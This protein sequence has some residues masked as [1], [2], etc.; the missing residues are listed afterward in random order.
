MN[1]CV[2]FFSFERNASL[3]SCLQKS[4]VIRFRDNG[5]SAGFVMWTLLCI[6]PAS[7]VVKIDRVESHLFLRHYDKRK[8][9]MKV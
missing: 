9:C 8:Y 1:Y 5:A 2:Y 3:V 6:Q 4:T 7:E